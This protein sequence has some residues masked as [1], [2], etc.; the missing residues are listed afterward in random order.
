MTDMTLSQ[1]TIA[2]EVSGL[3]PGQRIVIQVLNSDGTVATTL[4]DESVP[5]GK[6]YSGNVGYFGTL[7]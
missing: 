5:A 4:C 1:T 7:A 2:F 6:T 3:T